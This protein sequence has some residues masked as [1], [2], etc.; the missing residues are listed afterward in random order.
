MLSIYNA[1][2]Q[3]H[4][5]PPGTEC[6]APRYSRQHDGFFS[7]PFIIYYWTILYAGNKMNTRKLLLLFTLRPVT[8]SFCATCRNSTFLRLHVVHRSVD[9]PLQ[10]CFVSFSVL[11]GSLS[12]PLF[13]AVFLVNWP[14]LRPFFIMVFG[15]LIFPSSV[16]TV[17]LTVR[18][19]ALVL[20]VWFF[21]WRFCRIQIRTTRS[22][23]PDEYR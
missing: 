15:V 2:F 23:E 14:F 4:K 22:M 11:C 13:D 17:I 20:A 1:I 7:I 12:L 8:F 3:I 18:C 6:F 16:S 10:F 9:I 5:F 21:S 19:F